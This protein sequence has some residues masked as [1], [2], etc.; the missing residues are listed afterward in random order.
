MKKVHVQKMHKYLNQEIDYMNQI[1]QRI[2]SNKTG[3]WKVVE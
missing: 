3:Y 2:G 1:I